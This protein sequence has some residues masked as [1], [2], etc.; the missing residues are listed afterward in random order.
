[1]R[2]SSTRWRALVPGWKVS[3]EPLFDQP[4]LIPSPHCNFSVW[5]AAR[6]THQ[7]GGNHWHAY[8]KFRITLRSRDPLLFDIDGIHP[9]IK[10]SKGTRLD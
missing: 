5:G 6:E 7:D 9:N 3:K 2:S 4:I 10:A 8:V 1:M